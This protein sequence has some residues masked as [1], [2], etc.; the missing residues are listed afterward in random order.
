MVA[1][2]AER[3]AAG[4]GRAHLVIRPRGPG[5][6]DEIAAIA[7]EVQ[8]RDGYPGKRPHDM[9]T[10]MVD[11]GALGGWVAE[12]DGRIVG[13]VALHRSSLPVVMNRAREAAGASSDS[14]LA[15]V[16]RLVVDPRA[17]RVGAGRALLDQAAATAWELGRHP[18]LDVVTRFEAACALYASAGWSHV[19]EVQLRFDDGDVVNSLVFVAPKN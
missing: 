18:V 8:E 5:D 1:G 12:L 19:G 10:F 16:A 11:D 17:R 4:G 3:A 9:R 6:V 7:D 13:H 2:M 15:V 14:E